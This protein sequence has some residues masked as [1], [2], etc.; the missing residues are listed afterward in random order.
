[1]K[2]T[3]H[4]AGRTPL[5]LLFAVAIAALAGCTRGTTVDSGWAPGVPTGQSF[6]NVLVIGVTPDFNTRCRFER[7]LVDSLQKAGARAVTSCSRMTSKDPLTRDAVVGIIGGLGVDAV[8]STRLVDGRAGLVEGGTDEAR[9]EAYVKPVGYGYGYGYHP[10]YGPFGLP[11]TYV[12]F[13]AEEPSLTLRRTVVLSSNFYAVE[14]ATLVYSLDT[15]VRKKSS[16]FEVIDA[17]TTAL[18]ERL[19]RDGLLR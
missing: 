10:W 8:L 12:D 5:C 11:V 2:G 6:G 18:A 16:Q 15:V 4:R 14:G 13:V 7:L 1:M 17:L 3:L 9:G 19:K